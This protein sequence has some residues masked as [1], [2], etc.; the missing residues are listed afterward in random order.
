MRVA[1]SVPRLPMQLAF[2]ESLPRFHFSWT[3]SRTVVQVVQVVQVARSVRPPVAPPGCRPPRPPPPPPR[4][5]GCGLRASGAKV[6]AWNSRLVPVQILTTE[7]KV[8]K[9][10]TSLICLS[11]SVKAI[12]ATRKLVYLIQAF[13]RFRVLACI[14]VAHT[15]ILRISLPPL[16]KRP[17]TLETPLSHF[18]SHQALA[19]PDIFR[20]PTDS[21]SR[22]TS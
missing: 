5:S 17:A 13:E 12:A 20:N 14:L 18:K 15:H 21:R 4:P 8:F 11:L 1:S 6:V 19:Y 3:S 2:L 16:A 7:E 9:P 10:L 22:S